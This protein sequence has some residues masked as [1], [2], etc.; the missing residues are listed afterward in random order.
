MIIVI[1]CVVGYKCPLFHRLRSFIR[2][3]VPRLPG[4]LNG[5]HPLEGYKL[6]LRMGE[7]GVQLN[8]YKGSLFP[9]V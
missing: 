3:L 6:R 7:D 1:K 9:Y 2:S 5:K 8:S 4:A